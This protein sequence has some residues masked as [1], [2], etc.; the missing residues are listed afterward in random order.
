LIAESDDAEIAAFIEDISFLATQSAIIDTK[1]TY[2]LVISETDT[3]TYTLTQYV[4][5]LTAPFTDN[6]DYFEPA[7][8]YSQKRI[9]DISYYLSGG[10]I[11]PRTTPCSLWKTDPDN[12]QHLLLKRD[13]ALTGAGQAFELIQGTLIRFSNVQDYDQGINVIFVNTLTNSY[14]LIRVS[15]NTSQFAITNTIELI[16]GEDIYQKYI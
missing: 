4:D 2:A 12:G 1:N 6:R 5:V 16:P 7:T 15:T 11:A 13:I 14:T 10:C 3:S 8:A 9:D